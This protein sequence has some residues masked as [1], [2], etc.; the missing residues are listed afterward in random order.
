MAALVMDVQ[1]N[2]DPDQIALRAVCSESTLL[3]RA[4]LSQ[5]FGLFGIW[6]MLLSH[7]VAHLSYFTFL[8]I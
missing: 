1:T 3:D 5:Y 8:P 4:C 7:V 6:R 2:D